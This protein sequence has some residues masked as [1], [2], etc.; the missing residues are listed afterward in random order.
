MHKRKT[1]NKTQSNKE[2][3]RDTDREKQ[4]ATSSREKK[5]RRAYK[6]LEKVSAIGLYV[7]FPQS[8]LL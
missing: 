6:D 7:G 5:K 1:H 4:R 2:K 3:K 8:P